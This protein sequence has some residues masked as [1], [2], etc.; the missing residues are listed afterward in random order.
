[1]P[2]AYRYLIYHA[3]VGAKTDAVVAKNLSAGV[4]LINVPETE[5]LINVIEAESLINI[6]ETESLINL[7]DA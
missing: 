6:A 5:S 2:V 4:S 3:V 1:M 7:A